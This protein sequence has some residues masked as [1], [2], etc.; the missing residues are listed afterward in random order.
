[1]SKPSGP[2]RG[3]LERKVRNS[4]DEQPEPID[5]QDPT[6][7]VKVRGGKESKGTSL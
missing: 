7:P 4:R 6:E 3:S 5:K 1:M 2:K